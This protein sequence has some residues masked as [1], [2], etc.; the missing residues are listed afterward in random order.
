[1]RHA[2]M[3][4]Y[5]VND[6]AKHCIHFERERG[7]ELHEEVPGDTALKEHLGIR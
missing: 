5:Q 2:S 1:M 7:K 4:N 3:T 6:T